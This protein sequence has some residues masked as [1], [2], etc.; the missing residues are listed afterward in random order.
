MLGFTG[1]QPNL[2]GNLNIK[3]GSNVKGEVS[4]HIALL[5]SER[6]VSSVQ[7]HRGWEAPP[8]VYSIIGARKPLPQC[9]L[10][11]DL[12]DS[13]IYRIRDTS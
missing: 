9:C 12:Q 10:N 2:R 3:V 1:V 5:W 6:Q 4:I 8:T 7:Y 13:R 11:Q